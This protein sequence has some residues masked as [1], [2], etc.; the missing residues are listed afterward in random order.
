MRFF[1]HVHTDKNGDRCPFIW[2]G[3]DEADAVK[4]FGQYCSAFDHDP[5]LHE[6]VVDIHEEMEAA[7]ATLLDALF[8]RMAD[9]TS[10]ILYC[11]EE[12]EALKVEFPT[13]INN[14]RMNLDL[15]ALSLAAHMGRRVTLFMTDQK[16]QLTGLLI[17][18]G[19]RMGWDVPDTVKTEPA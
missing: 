15:T 18:H 8:G 6:K 17:N 7:K 14:Q 11:Y 4:R 1:L 12:S 5:D 9:D 13:Y 10:V 3:S 19:P 16:D 2:V